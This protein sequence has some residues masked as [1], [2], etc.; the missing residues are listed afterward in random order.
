MTTSLRQRVIDLEAFRRAVCKAA[1]VPD[2][3]T[4]TEVVAA[5]RA[6]TRWVRAALGL[7]DDTSDAEVQALVR[8]RTRRRK[9]ASR[10]TP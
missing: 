4:D 1:R 3:A 7:D 6:E 10:R 5:V 8:T 9:N 2:T